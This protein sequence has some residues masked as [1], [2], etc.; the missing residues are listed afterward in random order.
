MKKTVEE[1]MKLPYAIVITP[2]DGSYFVKVK[3]LEGCM[4]VGDTKAEA[5]EMIDDAMRGWLEI[6]LEDGLEIPLP[7]ALCEDKYSGK[8]ALRMTKSQHR[9]LAE[10]AEQEGVSMNQYMVGLLTEN[11]A[12]QE[13]LRLLK[14]QLAMTAPPEAE[15]AD[16]II[17]K[18]PNAKVVSLFDHRNVRMAGAI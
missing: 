10:G 15:Y 3:E 13:M 9:K 5:L 1:Y 18:R 12:Q 6:A 14:K 8:F 4:S 7:E 11:N 17:E 2:D 16:P